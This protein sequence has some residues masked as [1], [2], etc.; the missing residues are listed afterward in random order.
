MGAGNL[1]HQA[2]LM[3]NASG[4]GAPLDPEL[5][6]VGDAIGQRGPHR[7]QALRRHPSPQAV[8]AT[9]GPA[10][11]NANEREAAHAQPQ[12]ADGAT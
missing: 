6:Q 8:P 9:P 5:T 11:S 2:I 7:R 10:T 4:T 3:N 12:R 1:C